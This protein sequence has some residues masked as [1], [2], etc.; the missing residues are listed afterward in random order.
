MRGVLY[1]ARERE[2]GWS[3]KLPPLP[4]D[5]V[6]DVRFAGGWRVESVTNQHLEMLLSSLVAPLTIQASNLQKACIRL[7]DPLGG[8]L[9]NTTL[10]EGKPVVVG[11]NFK[12]LLLE[13]DG[14][15]PTQYAL[16]QNYPNPFNPSTQ[17][18]FAL[19]R[20]SDVTI[21]LYNA[22][23]QRV[24]TVAKG[25]FDAGY[26]HVE[27]GARELSSGVYLCRMAAGSYVSVKRLVVLK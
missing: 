1:L 16:G 15:M 5:G 27:L 7:V 3:W 13:C 20:S 24:A 19:P 17:I 26:H 9:L 12:S 22:L 11:A 23:G 4:P 14:V 6:F 8:E 10:Q 25:I 21:E 18:T 2:P